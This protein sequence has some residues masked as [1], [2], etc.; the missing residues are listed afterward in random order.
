VSVATT[1]HRHRNEPRTLIA[2]PEDTSPFRFTMPPRKPAPKRRAAAPATRPAAASRGVATETMD[3]AVVTTG[4]HNT[5]TV[6]HFHD[7]P[8]P[9]SALRDAYLHHVLRTAGQLSLAGIDPSAAGRASEA[10]ALHEVYTALLTSGH[11]RGP[12]VG[13]TQRRRARA[14]EPA[15]ALSAVE[16][17]DQHGR[18]VLLG[19]PGGLVGEPQGGAGHAGPTRGGA[20]EPGRVDEDRER[21]G[22]PLPRRGGLRGPRRPA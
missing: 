10:V 20:A 5:V 2:S 18:L 22:A 16:Q 8:E 4:D 6:N 1:V 21:A 3:Q 14:A 7:R 9:S 12:D 19:E 11:D 13:G 15:R 17:L